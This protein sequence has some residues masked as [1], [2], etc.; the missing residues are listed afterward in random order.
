M[1]PFARA[2]Q[3]AAASHAL[4][5]RDRELVEMAQEA[6]ARAYAPY[7][8]FAVGAAVRSN[9]EAIYAAANLENASFGLTICAEA[10]ALSLANSM[11]D[12]EIEAIAVVGFDFTRSADASGIVAPCGSCRQLIAEAAQRANCNVR[13]ICCN[14]RLDSIVISTI[15]ELLPNAFGSE[16]LLGRPQW[17][18]LH[19]EL[20]A[21]V[22]RLIATRKTQ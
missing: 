19:R 16:T 8:L 6:T 1:T 3:E 17:A 13:V 18:E 12:P 11:G 2:A 20:R 21:S 15:T 9:S 4:D 10:A 14:A 5:R 7:S 22:E